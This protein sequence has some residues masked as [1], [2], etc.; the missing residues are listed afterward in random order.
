MD[1]NTLL[2]HHQVALIDGRREAPGAARRWA[3]LRASYYAEQIAGTRHRLGRDG[4][5]TLRPGE[6]G[7]RDGRDRSERIVAHG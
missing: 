4:P 1:L 3:G 2:H 5:F 6:L 7:P